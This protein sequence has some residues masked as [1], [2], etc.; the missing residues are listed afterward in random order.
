MAVGGVSV[1]LSGEEALLACWLFHYISLSF[2]LVSCCLP[3]R[4]TGVAW[5]TWNEGEELFYFPGI[6]DME[7][8]ILSRVP[9]HQI[10][11]KCCTLH[12]F[13]CTQLTCLNLIWLHLG[14][15]RTGWGARARWEAWR[16]GE[17]VNQCQIKL[18]CRY[19]QRLIPGAT[20]M[21][22]I[23]LEPINNL[24]QLP[25]CFVFWV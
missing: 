19:R 23:W 17:R 18:H 21:A 7:K 13:W 3:C 2:A 9:K 15:Q 16:Q 22:V 10:W 8:L 1:N 11:A 14:T 20:A 6:G 12:Q 5:D 4:P 24:T 25:L